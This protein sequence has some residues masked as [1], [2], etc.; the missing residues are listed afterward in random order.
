[1]AAA[2]VPNTRIERRLER[3]PGRWIRWILRPSNPALLE[4]VQDVDRRATQLQGHLPPIRPSNPALL[5]D[6]Q[7][8]DR[9]TPIYTRNLIPAQTRSHEPKTA[10]AE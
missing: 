9:R 3:R 1:M 5:E 6:V 7:D 10:L 8:V 2:A 4:D